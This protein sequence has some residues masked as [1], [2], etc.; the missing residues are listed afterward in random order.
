MDKHTGELCTS[1]EETVS[2]FE[3][4]YKDSLNLFIKN[5]NEIPFTEN[6]EQKENFLKMVSRNIRMF[7]YKTGFDKKNFT[8]YMNFGNQKEDERF[9]KI[10]KTEG[11]LFFKEDLSGNNFSNQIIIGNIKSTVPFLNYLL[12][13]LYNQFKL[14]NNENINSMNNNSEL[15]IFNAKIK[16]LFKEKKIC[17]SNTKNL[18]I[19]VKGLGSENY[20]AFPI[21]TVSI[22]IVFKTENGTYL[23]TCSKEQFRNMFN[24]ES[25]DKKKGLDCKNLINWIEDNKISQERTKYYIVPS[26]ITIR[27]TDFSENSLVKKYKSEYEPSKFNDKL[28]DYFN[29]QKTKIVNIN[30]KYRLAISMNISN[31]LV[32]Y[33]SDYDKFIDE[34]TEIETLEDREVKITELHK[35]FLKKFKHLIQ[36]NLITQIVKSNGINNDLKKQVYNIKENI[37]YDPNEIK[38]ANNNNLIEKAPIRNSD[39]SDDSDEDK[40]DTEDKSDME[41]KSDIEDKSDNEDK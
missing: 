8:L 1:L 21:K 20:I 25:I 39:D 36:E 32:K 13:F 23:Y 29:S 34:E 10:M 12:T 4:E 3:K 35:K 16:Q 40:S 15:T 7:H 5:L 26:Q 30:L 9:V 14:I 11:T 18:N 17:T 22:E 24:K 33:E 2:K 37:N 31:K 27:K 41:N 38:V 6:K 19:N 28:E